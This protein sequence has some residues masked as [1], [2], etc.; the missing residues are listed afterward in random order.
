MI[1][2][3]TR[4]S[5]A[6]RSGMRKT[7][8]GFILVGVFCLFICRPGGVATLEE[9]PVSELQSRYLT[10]DRLNRLRTSQ[11]MRTLTIVQELG[12]AALAHAEYMASAR[13]LTAQEKPGEA[14]FT[15]II[16]RDRALYAGYRGVSVLEVVGRGVSSYQDLLEEALHDP[17]YR[18]ALLHPDYDEE[19]IYNH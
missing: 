4:M 9:E 14:L 13:E 8:I 5:G 1:N 18:Y 3:Q 2:K 6:L 10:N 7:L 15:G 11:G 12:N 17:G 19:Y 16:A